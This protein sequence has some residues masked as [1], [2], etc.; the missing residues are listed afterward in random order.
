MIVSGPRET[1][2]S[3]PSLS[4]PPL[5]VPSISPS[6]TER[7]EG[8]YKDLGA[9]VNF[10]VA[11]GRFTPAHV[12]WDIQPGPVQLGQI[13]DKV[14]STGRL[15]SP[16]GYQHPRPRL[17]NSRT[18]NYLFSLS[19]LGERRDDAR[20]RSRRR[21]EPR[22]T[23]SRN[24]TMPGGIETHFS[25]AES[26]PLL[27]RVD[28]HWRKRG[29]CANARYKNFMVLIGSFGYLPVSRVVKYR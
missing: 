29:G 24:G 11:G 3:P 21:R 19:Y 18:F 23:S 28:R 15:R 26:R 5:P 2:A 17:A 22:F 20:S 6:T 1:E 7:R 12:N 16:R 13:R 4:P 8:R 27:D 10:L 9:G 14:R 25:K